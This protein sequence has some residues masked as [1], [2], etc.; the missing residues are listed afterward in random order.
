[1]MQRP[2][3]R[4]SA[5]FI[6]CSTV[7]AAW[8]TSQAGQA[9]GAKVSDATPTQIKEALKHFKA[10]G[11]AAAKHN[12]ANAIVEYRASLDIIDSPNSRLELARALRDDGQPVEAWTEYGRTLDDA[13]ALAVSEARYAKTA[14][15]AA[16]ERGELESKIAI[17]TVTV[18]DAPPGANLRIGT[19]LV[20]NDNWG[21]PFPVAAV[22]QGTVEVVLVADG[23]EIARQAVQA[24]PGRRA[25]TLARP[26][27]TA[28]VAAVEAPAAQPH[29]EFE[30][31]PAPPAEAPAR[32]STSQLRPWAFVAGGVGVAGLAT[33][34][35]SGTLSHSAYN[36]L[37]ATCHGVC[38]PGHEGEISSGKT[39]QAVANVGLVIG[40]LGVAAGAGLFILSLPHAQTSNAA[41]VVG[42]GWLGVRGSL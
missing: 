4:R 9:A 24:D 22:A 11:A 16:L 6:A 37:Q 23:T 2:I 39:E 17:L 20:A 12:L 34:V 14:D 29:S 25:V 15:A 1:M 35:I 31:E 26:K 36:D 42:P 30:S 38:P 28:P 33:F 32:S 41:V 7:L 18:E 10:G 13:K 19:V 27:P 21:K 40:A 3:R 8:L 5:A